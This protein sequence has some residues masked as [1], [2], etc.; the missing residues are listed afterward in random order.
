MGAFATL[1]I[2]GF[3]IVFFLMAYGEVILLSSSLIET[4]I[5]VGD[6]SARRIDASV[7]LEVVQNSQDRIIARF[8]PRGES[9]RIDELEKIDLL[10]AYWSTG[11]DRRVEWRRYGSPDGWRILNVSLS[12]GPEILNPVDL[13]QRSGLIDPAETAYMEVWMPPDYNASLGAVLILATPSG[14]VGEG[15]TP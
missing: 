12:G 10:V 9:L 13:S 8:T 7:S 6:P 5:R 1:V 2:F 3:F 11:G 15:A 14:S 4:I